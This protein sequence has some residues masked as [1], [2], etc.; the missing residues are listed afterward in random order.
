MI[1]NIVLNDDSDSDY[2]IEYVGLRGPERI[3]D[4][5]TLHEAYIVNPHSKLIIGV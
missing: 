2:V 1:T 3:V 5:L 4:D